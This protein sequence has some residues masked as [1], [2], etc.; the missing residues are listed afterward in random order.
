MVLNWYGCGGYDGLAVSIGIEVAARF[1]GT[2]RRER[3][4]G[5]PPRSRMAY[6]HRYLVLQRHRLP[7]RRNKTAPNRMMVAMDLMG[8]LRLIDD[9][10]A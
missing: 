3:F 7:K 10:L 9:M 5:A 4:V 1:T 2:G 8:R 6:M